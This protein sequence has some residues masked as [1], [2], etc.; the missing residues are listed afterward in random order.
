[1]ATAYSPPR[2]NTEGSAV[3]RREYGATMR[4]HSVSRGWSA[5][6]HMMVGASH[7]CETNT[8]YGDLKG[9]NYGR[10]TALAASPPSWHK[11]TGVRRCLAIGGRRDLQQQQRSKTFLCSE[12]WPVNQG[13][14]TSARIWRPCLSSLA[15]DEEL[16]T[17][18]RETSRTNTNSRA[19]C[20]E[21]TSQQRSA[22]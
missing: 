17:N 5:V 19:S 8:S 22:T 9:G 1:M 2:A 10:R 13:D 21:Q 6:Q 20:V 18:H 11:H 16:V 14:L 7:V 4:V 15:S 3:A 12:R